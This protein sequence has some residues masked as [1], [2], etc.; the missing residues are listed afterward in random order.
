M[1]TRGINGYVV[2]TINSGAGGSFDA[3]FKIPAELFGSYQISI[4]LQ[5]GGYYPYYSYNWFYNNTTSGAET[6]PPA[7][8]PPP[9]PPADSQGDAQGAADTPEEITPGGTGESGN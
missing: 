2:G 5:S 7:T 1:G 9:D 8:T 6:A 3:T 4:R